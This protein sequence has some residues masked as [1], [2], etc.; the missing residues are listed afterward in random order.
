MAASPSVVRHWPTASKFSRLKPSGSMRAWQLAHTG[1]ARCRS[2]ISRTD[3]GL[4]DLALVEVGVHVGRR[5]RHRRRQDVLEQPLAAN[6]RRRARRV[7][8]DG[9][10]ARLAEQA[11]AVLV[12]Q[13]HAPEVAAVDAG[14]PVVTR[15]LLVEERV[16]GRQQIRRCCGPPSADRRGTAPSRGRTRRAGCRRTR[17]TFVF[18]SGVSSQTLRVCSHWPKKLSTSAARARGSASI[19]RTC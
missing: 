9:Q 16:V 18:A 14:D 15:E 3:R 12:G 11:P 4:A 2:S 7:R 1:L 8:R 17:G 6:G 5:R 10:H 19:R 13:R